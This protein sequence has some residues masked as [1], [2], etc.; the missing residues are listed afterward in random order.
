MAPLLTSSET[1]LSVSSSIK[2]EYFL[3][4]WLWGFNDMESHAWPIG[5]A[6][7]TFTSVWLLFPKLP[8]LLV[9]KRTT[10]ITF[11]QQTWLY[12][13]HRKRKLS[14]AAL[15]RSQNERR[16]S[17]SHKCHGFLKSGMKKC[18]EFSI[19]EFMDCVLLCLGWLSS[20]FLLL[21]QVSINI[22]S[23]RK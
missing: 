2:W 13:W 16:M 18:L 17:E 6:Q 19:M 22:Q 20:S 4:R 5:R 15:G 1:W 8:S 10:Q 12:L 7:Y 3:P 9:R 23:L 11:Q 21:L 14:G